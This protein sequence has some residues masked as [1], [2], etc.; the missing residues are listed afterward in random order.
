M[1]WKPEEALAEFPA[2][3][4]LGVTSCEQPVAPEDTDGLALLT[5]ESKMGLWWMKA[6]TTAN[7]WT[8]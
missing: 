7:R 1:A 5:R 4:G 6:Y 2:L 8:C 3:F